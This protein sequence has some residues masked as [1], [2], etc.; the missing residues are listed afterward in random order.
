MGNA[1]GTKTSGEAAKSGGDGEGEG[2]VESNN[3]ELEKS[4]QVSSDVSGKREVSLGTGSGELAS[5]V[6]SGKVRGT[7]KSK[8]KRRIAFRLSSRSSG[9]KET[10]LHAEQRGKTQGI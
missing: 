7:G 3:P 9:T 4:P 5:P 2:D 6:P 8:S 1:T 10:S